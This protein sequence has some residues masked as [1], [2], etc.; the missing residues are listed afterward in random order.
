MLRDILF[1]YLGG[2]VGI[3]LGGILWGIVRWSL[4]ERLSCHDRTDLSVP[5][6]WWSVV[7]TGLIGASGAL[8]YSLFVDTWPPDKR[9]HALAITALGPLVGAICLSISGYFLLSPINLRGFGQKFG[10]LIGILLPVA[11]RNELLSHLGI[12][13]IR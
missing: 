12:H 4:K 11:A 9:F 1:L 5:D 3:A 7:L 13:V 2:L 8:A 10:S 6:P